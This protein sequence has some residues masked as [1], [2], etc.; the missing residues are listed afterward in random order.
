MTDP[1]SSHRFDE[2]HPSDD[3]LASFFVGNLEQRD[4]H[5]IEQHLDECLSCLERL[6]RTEPVDQFVSII[7]QNGAGR[8]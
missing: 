7:R 1:I 8:F 3:L 5:R 6:M 4:Q 2:Q